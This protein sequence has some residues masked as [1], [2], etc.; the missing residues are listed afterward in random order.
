MARR[1]LAALAPA[2]PRSPIFGFSKKWQGDRGFGISYGPSNLDAHY[3]RQDNQVGKTVAA[4][5]TDSAQRQRRE[6][7]DVDMWGDQAAM[8]MKR[9]RQLTE[10]GLSPAQ[11]QKIVSDEAS[12]VKPPALQMGPPTPGRI[13]GTLASDWFKAQKAKPKSGIDSMPA[14]PPAPKTETTP[15]AI[16][17]KPASPNRAPMASPPA[18]TPTYMPPSVAANGSVAPSMLKDST[19]PAGQRFSALAPAKPVTSVTAQATFRPN[20]PV[21]ALDRLPKLGPGSAFKPR[22]AP[23]TGPGSMLKNIQAQS[24]PQVIPSEAPNEVARRAYEAPGGQREQE[25]AR[26]DMEA[27]TQAWFPKKPKPTAPQFQF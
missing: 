15:S 16:A 6:G 24:Q 7:Q 25:R 20:G 26:A 22:P 5:N 13:E 3:A 4:L 19:L 23:A 8:K 2:Q 18:H 9:T 12:A 10:G 27:K 17:A 14:D 11:A 1:T 21:L